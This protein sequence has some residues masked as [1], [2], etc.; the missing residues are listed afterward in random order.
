MTLIIKREKQ[1]DWYW[2]SVWWVTICYKTA[3]TDAS[4]W[5]VRLCQ[6][7]STRNESR[8]L[9]E[10]I[11]VW[12]VV[13]AQLLILCVFVVVIRLHPWPWTCAVTTRNRAT[14]PW[15]TWQY[16]PTGKTIAHTVFC[17]C[18]PTVHVKKTLLT[19]WLP[20]SGKTK[21]RMKLSMS[22]KLM[23]HNTEPINV[24]YLVWTY[25]CLIFYSCLCCTLNWQQSL[26]LQWI[27]TVQSA[28]L[29]V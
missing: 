7:Q 16:T 8:K 20:R 23:E 26:S 4:C 17:L 24:L 5:C 15:A 29:E 28:C 21:W 10:T 18:D 6:P 2:L 11:I 9:P 25:F 27:N 3:V 22:C 14:V 1:S 13:T 19:V 12:G